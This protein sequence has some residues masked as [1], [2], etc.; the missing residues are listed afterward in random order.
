MKFTITIRDPN[1]LEQIALFGEPNRI[2]A[3]T[4]FLEKYLVYGEI[5]VLEFDTED[6]GHCKIFPKP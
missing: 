2:Q 4:S 6:P 3:A 1:V 5:L